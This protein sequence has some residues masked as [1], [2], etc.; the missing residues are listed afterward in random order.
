VGGDQTGF[1]ICHFPILGRLKKLTKNL[2]THQLRPQE[3]E[4]TTHK[5]LGMEG[6]EGEKLQLIPI[7]TNTGKETR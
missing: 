5:L 4:K 6:R 2:K 7:I 1:D 3:R